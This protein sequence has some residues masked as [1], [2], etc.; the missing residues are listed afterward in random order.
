M[1]MAIFVAPII[2]GSTYENNVPQAHKQVYPIQT[3]SNAV[4]LWIGALVHPYVED[5]EQRWNHTFP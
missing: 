2:I 4:D 1:L 5:L 3:S